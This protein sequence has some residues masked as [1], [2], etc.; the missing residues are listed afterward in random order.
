MAGGDGEK[1]ERERE[2]ERERGWGGVYIELWAMPRNCCVVVM[3]L[4]VQN[5]RST[6]R[7]RLCSCNMLKSQPRQEDAFPF[8]RDLCSAPIWPDR[9]HPVPREDDR[10]QWQTRA[11]GLSWPA[12]SA[13]MRGC[14]VGIFLFF[15]P[16]SSLS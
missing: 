7:S 1:G 13:C 5:Y 9:H 8:L 12:G 11:M 6:R 15:F 2:R 16:R 4:K 3:Y 14:Y 10:Y